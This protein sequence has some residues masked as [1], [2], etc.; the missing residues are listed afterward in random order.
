MRRLRGTRTERGIT[1]L[2]VAILAVVLF[3]CLA[4]VS[5]LGFAYANQRRIQTGADAA[6]LAVGRKIAAT[7][8]PTDT[9]TTVS[10]NF[11]N[12]TTRAIATSVFAQ[13]VGAGAQLATGATG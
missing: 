2:L 4:F 5:D 1:S 8:G 6:A 9:C 13:N 10:T 3:G 11:N 7:A 12:A